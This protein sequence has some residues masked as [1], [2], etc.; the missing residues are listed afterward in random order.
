MHLNDT[1]IL[2]SYLTFNNIHLPY[3]TYRLPI[4]HIKDPLSLVMPG[5]HHHTVHHTWLLYSI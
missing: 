4:A 3:R 5:Y 2:N 1:T